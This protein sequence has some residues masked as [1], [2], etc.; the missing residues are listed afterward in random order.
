MVRRYLRSIGG[1]EMNVCIAHAML[2]NQ[3]EWA[4]VLPEGPNGDYITNCCADN[5]TKIVIGN[6]C[7]LGIGIGWNSSLQI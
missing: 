2:G 4:S 1:D 5:G 7:R 6:G 3:A